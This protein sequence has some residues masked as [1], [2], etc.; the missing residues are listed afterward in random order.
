[1]ESL[2][3][4]YIGI[5]IYLTGML[6]VGIYASKRIS[7]TED[8]LVAGRRLPLWLCTA[9]LTATFF[10][11]GTIMGAAGA[12]YKKGFLGVI[13]DPFG[14]TLCL[15]L[16]GLFFIRIMRRMRLTTIVDFFE[17]RFGKTSGLI[18][19]IIMLSV[20]IG[21]TGSLLVSL[22]FILHTITGISTNTAIIIGTI[23]VFIYTMAGGM[24]AVS[25]TDFFQIIIVI[26]GLAVILP[27]VISKVGGFSTLVSSLP[28]DSFRMTPKEGG[29][30]EWL[31]Y[32]RAWM[33]IGLGNLAGQ[34]LL[35]R[36][37]SAK[38]EE[39]AQNSAYLSSV[40]YLVFGIIAVLIGM[41]GSLLI[42]GLE[43]PE[44]VI[45]K[46]ALKYLPPILASLFISALLAAVMSSADSSILACSSV[47]GKNLLP[48][49]WKSDSDQS[50]LKWTRLSVPVF[51]F[52]SML[53]ALFVGE[54]YTLLLDSFSILLV[55][56][57]VP[58]TAG[59]WWPKANTTAALC[60]MILGSV[61]WIA[62]KFITPGIP[63]DMIGLGVSVGAMVLVTL[64]TKNKEAANP[65][66]DVDGN[67]LPY[68]DRLGTLSLFT[69]KNKN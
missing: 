1:M 61:S 66:K 2:T 18:A 55:G 40:I 20:Y 24:W 25:L 17:I 16:A 43:N 44:L 19:S 45:P 64:F 13:A 31:N 67:I 56:L 8:F 63:S 15:F 22:G 69:G 23:I 58:L 34:D 54:V 36:S 6:G 28:E 30:I 10:G 68:V 21:W 26:T 42:P 11:G 51:A 27:I 46:L 35:Q 4:I 29:S 59:I 41:A 48:W 49:I 38:N 32:V 3:V 52:L 14:A 53:V 37:L 9:A 60:A 47:L 57:F 50:V 39:V 7:G 62:F 65:I 33:V 12:A 5:I